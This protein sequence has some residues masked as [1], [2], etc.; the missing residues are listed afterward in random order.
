MSLGCLA[1]FASCIAL[2]LQ[3]FAVAHVDPAPSLFLAKAGSVFGVTFSVLF[4]GEIL[5]GPLFAG[6]SPSS[7]LAS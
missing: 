4:L 2:L 7:S 3:N 6:S 5:T 1:V